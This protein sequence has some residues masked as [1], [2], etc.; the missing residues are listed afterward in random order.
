MDADTRYVIQKISSGKWAVFMSWS[1][2]EMG[3]GS[4]STWR[5]AIAAANKRVALDK[6]RKRA[7]LDR[8]A[9]ND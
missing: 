7:K 3:C 1:Q 4:Y 2:F 5:E 6:W 8:L 9:V